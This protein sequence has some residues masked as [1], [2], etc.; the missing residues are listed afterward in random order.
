M[1]DF[2]LNALEVGSTDGPLQFDHGNPVGPITVGLSADW[3]LRGQRLHEIH[4]Y[5]HFDGEALFVCPADPEAMVTIDTLEAPTDAWTEVPVGGTLALGAVRTRLEGKKLAGDGPNSERTVVKLPPK[6][7]LARPL[8]PTAFHP[9]GAEGPSAAPARTEPARPPERPSARLE[10]AKPERPSARLESHAP[11]RPSMRKEA[12]QPE[13]PSAGSTSAA[14]ARGSLGRSS[15][16]TPA[17]PMAQDPLAMTGPQ[18]PVGFRSGALPA[19]RDALAV[20]GPN[21]PYRSSPAIRTVESDILAITGPHMAGRPSSGSMPIAGRAAPDELTRVGQPLSSLRM[22]VEP[23]RNAS[24]QPFPVPP[25]PALASNPPMPAAAV[26]PSG[27]MPAAGAHMPL[28]MSAPIP[29][30]MPLPMSGPMPAAMPPPVS[31]PMPAAMPPPM[32]A[33]PPPMGAFPPGP[34]PQMGGPMG[35]PGG[36]FPPAPQMGGFPPAPQAGQKGD[37]P[38][39]RAK[40]KRSPARQA[41]LIVGVLL[42]IPLALLNFVRATAPSA[43][44]GASPRGSGPLA[45][46]PDAAAARPRIVVLGAADAGSALTSLEPEATMHGGGGAVDLPHSPSTTDPGTQ[47]ARDAGAS[48]GKTARVERADGGAAATAPPV[49]AV[50]QGDL[51]KRAVEAMTAGRF[52]EAAELYGRLAD[53]TND[54]VYR[55]AERVAR[56]R[57]SGN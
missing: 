17:V 4:A 15:V 2:E 37:V 1:A 26:M 47:Q 18:A 24:S 32:Q 41:L 44:R 13:R 28:P 23:P 25:P 30:A 48:K 46:R 36:S 50:A 38:T 10:P 14:P 27:A 5:L 3:P 57:A 29:A 19:A 42:L 56:R 39:G 45:N 8:S 33:P 12:V 34:A 9:V 20:T 21:L 51:P 49:A 31:G 22:P 43:P 55:I 53:T 52:A 11:E 54:P 7:K 35:P 6:P 40:K 16:G